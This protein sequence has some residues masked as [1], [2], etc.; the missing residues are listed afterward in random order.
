MASAPASITSK[1]EF[2][3]T[4]D[5]WL[6]VVQIDHMGAGPRRQRRARRQRVPHRGGADPH[7]QRA[8]DD[9]DN[10]FINGALK[11]THPRRRDPQPTAVR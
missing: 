8:R 11:L 3:N 1:D 4:T 5:G 7:G 10:P 2:T 9:A 6:G